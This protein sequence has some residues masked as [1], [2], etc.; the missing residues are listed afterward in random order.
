M[1]GPVPDEG[2]C[3]GLFAL[4]AYERVWPKLSDR[5]AYCEGPYDVRD[6]RMSQCMA[7]A[8]GLH[9]CGVAPHR[10]GQL[11][12]SLF[13]R[14]MTVGAPVFFLGLLHASSHASP[15]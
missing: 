9:A 7:G 5:S 2:Y 10:L 6:V 3:A 1:W 8:G 13:L 12:A 15:A 11:G 4:I 14:R